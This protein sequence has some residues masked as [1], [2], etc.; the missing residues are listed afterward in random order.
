[1]GGSRPLGE[2]APLWVEN[3][4]GARCGL[5]F[6]CPACS[7]LPC[8][9]AH[10]IFVEVALAPSHDRSDGTPVWAANQ[11]TELSSLTLTPSIDGTG[12]EAWYYDDTCPGRVLRRCAFHGWIRAGLVVW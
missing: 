11:T 1:M 5:I 7:P 3:S 10:R 12:D 2:L 8:G 9:H 4:A 6:S